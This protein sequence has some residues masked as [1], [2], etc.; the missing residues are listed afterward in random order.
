MDDWLSVT[1]A[2]RSIM[3]ASL[4]ILRCMWTI[5]IYCIMNRTNWLLD[6]TTTIIKLST[7]HPQTLHNLTLKYVFFIL[8]LLDSAQRSQDL[9]A[10]VRIRHNQQQISS[11]FINNTH[12]GR[13]PHKNLGK[14]CY[15]ILWRAELLSI[16]LSVY[17]SLSQKC[18][19]LNKS[20]TRKVAPAELAAECFL[21]NWQQSP[22]A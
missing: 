5:Y 6:P 9:L 18:N 12:S 16:M 14:R 1:D 22:V 21:H 17:A 19:N 2:A 10:E 11:C 20:A 15:T 3:A 4:I 7:L 13:I 8:P